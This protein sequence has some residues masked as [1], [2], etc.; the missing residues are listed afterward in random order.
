MAAVGASELLLKS[1]KSIA[2]RFCPFEPNVR[3]V[4][5]F[6]EKINSKK[7]RSTNANCDIAVDI[8]HDRSEPCV[9]VLFADGERLVIKGSNVT[10]KEMLLALNVKCASKDQQAKDSGRK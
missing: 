3:H 8:R 5:E 7:I 9:D 4:R 1:V 10:S 6:V 2:V